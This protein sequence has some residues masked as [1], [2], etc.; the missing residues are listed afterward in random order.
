MSSDLH[1][2]SGLWSQQIAAQNGRQTENYDK[3][4]LASTEVNG[5]W[6][7]N[8]YAGILADIEE[9]LKKDPATVHPHY[10]GISKVLKAF[11]YSMLVD[12]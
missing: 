2:Y 10:F 7:N 9:I 5:V 3:Y 1:R 6:R 12:F 11:T 8:L 4:I